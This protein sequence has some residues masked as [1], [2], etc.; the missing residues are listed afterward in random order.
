VNLYPLPPL[1]EDPRF[2]AGLLFDAAKL[3]RDHHYPMPS[4][5]ADLI[6]L[7]TALFE[8]L[9]GGPGERASRGDRP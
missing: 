5:G 8:F 6:R 2:T 3:L 1:D 4:S 9:Y 7:Q